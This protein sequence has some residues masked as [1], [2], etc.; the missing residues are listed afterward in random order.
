MY[1]A[2]IIHEQARGVP[3]AEIER[4]TS[5]LTA[6]TPIEG[7]DSG[8]FDISETPVSPAPQATRRSKVRT[9]GTQAHHVHFAGD[10]KMKARSSKRVFK[11]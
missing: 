8:R 11:F 6:I 4:T 3:P 2:T 1:A 9:N 10:V 5:I 7:G